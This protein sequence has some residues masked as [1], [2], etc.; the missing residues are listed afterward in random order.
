MTIKISIEIE[1]ID[2]AKS[3]TVNGVTV[4][5]TDTVLEVIGGN[6]LCNQRAVCDQQCNTVSEEAR[7]IASDTDKIIEF[8]E[9]DD[10]DYTFRS[11]KAI[12][13]GTSLSEDRVRELCTNSTKIRRNSGSKETW[14][15]R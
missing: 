6:S 15:T 8:L 7:K 11:T 5:D 13:D 2:N 3:V 4:K 10:S 9:D 1:G 12:A 14:A